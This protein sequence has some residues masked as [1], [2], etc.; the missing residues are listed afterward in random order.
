MDERKS[1][2]D[3][4]RRT[5]ANK[6]ARRHKFTEKEFQPYVK[7]IGQLL[8]AWNDLHERLAL[9]FVMSIGGGWVNRPLALW[10][11]VRGDHGKRKMLKVAINELPDTEKG[12]REKLVEEIIWVL[13]NID[14]LK[15]FRDDAAHTPLYYYPPLPPSDN[16]L[17]RLIASGVFPDDAV[18][19]PRA[20][21]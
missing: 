15:D 9:L 11:S 8:L 10:H 3:W 1:L 6:W 5:R 13:E 18:G 14:K 7:A 21:K 4:F 16:A 17:A 20:I 12:D 19:N 2:E